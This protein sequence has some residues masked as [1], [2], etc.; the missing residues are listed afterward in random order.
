MYGS[1]TTTTDNNINN[2]PNNP[3]PSPTPPPKGSTLTSGILNL[4]N[5]IVGAGMLGLPGAFAGTGHTAGMALLLV[6]AT[7]SAHGLVLLSK[8]ATAAGL[9][10][11]FYS[12][13]AAA[14]PRYT[15]L[16]DLAVALKCFGVAT[17][18]TTMDYGVSPAG[19]LITISDSMV[20]ALDHL[21]LTGDPDKDNT[22]LLRLFLSRRFWVVG[23]LLSV[24][25]FS[26]YRTLDELKRASALALVFVVLLV[27]MIVL[28]AHGIADPCV[29]VYEEEC[30]GDVVPLTDFA[31]TVSKIPVFVFAFTCQQNIFPI[32]NEMESSSSSLS[33]R[34]VDIV[35]VAA[36]GLALLIFSVVAVEGYRT[37]GSLARGDILLNYPENAQVT[38]LRICI[39]F[40]LALHYP[41]QLDPS[42]RCISSLVN[43]L[44]QSWESYR[45]RTEYSGGLSTRF[46]RKKHSSG[47]ETE[48]GNTTTHFLSEENESPPNHS[49][50]ESIPIEDTVKTDPEKMF[51]IITISFLSLSFLLAMM[52][53]DLGIVLALVGATG[54]TLVS[55]V[56]PGLIY[57]KLHQDSSRCMAWVQLMVGLCVMPL[58][59]YFILA[60]KVVH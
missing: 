24:L 13:A 4:S 29:H 19:Y 42:R 47:L 39:S 43:V 57:L 38:I 8:S 5:T 35:I 1:T 33:Q 58:S 18:T 56:L 21:L 31:S 16:I 37:F 48:L 11:S 50:V 40:M 3:S 53:D 32:V 30:R 14:V 60:R 7:F 27:A 55:Y 15:V 9:P 28:Y 20:D 26:F 45:R 41:L 10:S 46:F 59:L 22:F 6:A 36:I 34:R 44:M 2:D 25:P 52:V 54:S 49:Y 23:A 12:V 51:Y 17:D